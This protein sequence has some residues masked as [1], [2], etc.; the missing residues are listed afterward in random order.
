VTIAVARSF[1]IVQPIG[2]ARLL[3]QIVPEIAESIPA[4]A[5]AKGV[6]IGKVH[7]GLQ[8]TF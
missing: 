8:L 7:P 1:L 2:E 6:F 5:G 3:S 4:A